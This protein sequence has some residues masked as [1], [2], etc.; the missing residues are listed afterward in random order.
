ML[1]LHLRLFVQ[2]FNFLLSLCPWYTGCIKWSCQIKFVD[3]QVDL[4]LLYI[5]FSDIALFL[6]Y[7]DES[8]RK[9]KVWILRPWTGTQYPISFYLC[10]QN[11]KYVSRGCFH[12]SVH[13]SF[14]STVIAVG[15]IPTLPARSRFA[16][17]TIEER[18]CLCSEIFNLHKGCLSLAQ[19]FSS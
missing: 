1:S 13:L 11:T 6:C 16:G 10:P 14:L 2:V 15:H 8:P 3:V 17:W 4:G 9:D 5:T 18:F 7:T 12:H 19:G